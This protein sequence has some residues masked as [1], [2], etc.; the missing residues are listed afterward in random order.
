MQLPQAARH[1]IE[2]GVLIHLVTVNTD[3]SPQISC[4]WAGLDGDDLLVA[5]LDDRQKLRNVRRNPRV[6]LS[7]QADKKDGIGLQHYLVIHGT[8]R[9]EDGGAPQLLQKLAF[10]YIGEG[11]KFPAMPNPPP[12]FIMRIT[13][14]RIAGNGPWMA[15][16]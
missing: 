16:R 3:G 2:S 13:P 4:V 6:A 15:E 11:V 8:A 1:L 10:R 5:S 7:L 12:G 14:D 9:V